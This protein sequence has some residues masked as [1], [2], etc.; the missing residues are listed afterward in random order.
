[1]L[2]TI[3]S[4]I[5]CHLDNGYSIDVIYL[6]F[7]KA[8]DIVPHQHLLQ[9]LTSFG[10]HGN[11][12]KWIENFLS[13]RKQQVVLNGHQ[14][15]SIPVTSGM[16]QGSVLG[17]LLFTMFVNEIPSIVSS[18]VLMFADDMKIFRV[19]RN[20]DDYTML[21]NDLRDLL[22]RSSHQWQLKFN[23]SKCKHLHFGTAHH[24]GTQIELDTSHSDL[25]I[26][27]DSQLKFHDHTAQV[28]TK[29]NRVLGLIKKLF[30]YLDPIMLTQ[31]FSR[32][33][34]PM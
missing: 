29:A 24:H 4:V 13:N 28:T 1:M 8:F 26:L 32:L 15:C 7:Q 17:P 16:P 14:S 21:Q 6:D 10:I 27:F 33:V 11:I 9:K 25:G 22:H 31:L 18:P 3:T 34:R 30:D 23:V 12:L 19:I 5:T 20:K 2:H